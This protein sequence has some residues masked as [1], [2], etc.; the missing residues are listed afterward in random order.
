[1]ARQEKAD[2]IEALSEVSDIL[3]CG[4]D[5][6]AIELLLALADQGGLNAEALASIVLGLREECIRVQAVE[7][8]ERDARR[9]H[10]LNGV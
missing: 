2:I 6:R 4:L 3:R 7:S 1:M 8:H 9:N 10:R 5:R